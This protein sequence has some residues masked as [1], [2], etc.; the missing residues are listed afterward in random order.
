MPESSFLYGNSQNESLFNKK[1]ALAHSI[2]ENP[3]SKNFNHS[4][5]CRYLGISLTFH[6]HSKTFIDDL[7]DHLPESWL[8][9]V[10]NPVNIYLM[11]PSLFNFSKKEWCEE[12]SQNCF[13]NNSSESTY[14]LQR[15]FLAVITNDIFLISEEVLGDGFYNFL[16]TY[17]SRKIIEDKKVIFHSSCIV[18]RDNKAR[19]F[20]GHSGAGKTTITSLAEGRVVLGDDMILCEVKND[21]VYASPAAIGGAF[22]P[23]VSY[24][25]SFEVAGFY[26]LEQS[27]QNKVSTFTKIQAKTKLMASYANLFWESL[28]DNEI[29]FLMDFSS[30]I[31]NRCPVYKLDFTQTSDFWKE[32]ENA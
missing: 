20:I 13:E 31:L 26:W 22:L 19:F 9:D 32:I 29:G 8:S 27:D 23:N 7:S 16:R 24:D 11:D 3:P 21:K 18:G 30:K 5:S 2:I 1:K 15:D 17:L 28:E 25:E 10:Q 14:Y 12:I 6:S 4:L